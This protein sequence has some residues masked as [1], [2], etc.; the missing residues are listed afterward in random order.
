MMGTT[1]T[2]GIGI[3]KP[4]SNI[5]YADRHYIVESS[6]LH[7]SVLTVKAELNQLATG[8]RALG[9]LDMVQANPKLLRPLFVHTQSPPPLTAGQMIDLFVQTC[10]PLDRTDEMTK[11]R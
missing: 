8:L 6:A 10:L 2:N 9:V 11:K 7:Y 5:Q 4:I 1:S 3:A